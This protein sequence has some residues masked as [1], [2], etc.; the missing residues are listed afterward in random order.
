MAPITKGP[1]FAIKVGTIWQ[2]EITILDN[3][4]WTVCQRTKDVKISA[5][6]A[7]KN[8]SRSFAHFSAIYIYLEVWT[9]HVFP[10]SIEY[11]SQKRGGHFLM[12]LLYRM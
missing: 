10:D 11:A 4:S 12:R 6:S 8:H 2:T 3:R 9:S 1:L 5:E 7:K